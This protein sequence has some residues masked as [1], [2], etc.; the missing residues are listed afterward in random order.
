MEHCVVGYI[1]L[2]SGVYDV[3]GSDG[4]VVGIT[5]IFT[6]IFIFKF[7]KQQSQHSSQDVNRYIKNQREHKPNTH[8]LP[9]III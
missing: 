4:I 5:K 7:T 8:T 1:L 6:D 9:N 2:P 3:T